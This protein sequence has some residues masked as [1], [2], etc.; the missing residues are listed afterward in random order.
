MSHERAELAIDLWSWRLALDD[1]EIERLAALLSPDERARARRFVFDRHRMR[2]VAAR[3]R[4]REIL[5][6]IVGRAPEDLVFSYGEHGKPALAGIADAPH[7]NLSHSEDIAVLAVASR[8]LGADVEMI[9]PLQEDVAGRFFSDAE[10][11]ALQALPAADRRAGFY[12]CWT[13]KEAVIKALG[14]GLSLPLKTF[15]VSVGEEARLTRLHGSPDAARGWCLAHLE[16]AP[17]YVGAL[18]CETGGLKPKVRVRA[19]VS[20][21]PA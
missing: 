9:R 4:L 18:A 1:G 7:F 13:R 10:I 3:G 8:E 20:G 14:S 12:R 17:G 16:P 2:F 15:D 5:G 19:S 21:S 6:G 11:A